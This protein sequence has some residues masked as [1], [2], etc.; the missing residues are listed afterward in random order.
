RKC[1]LPDRA[2]SRARGLPATSEERHRRAGSWLF[3]GEGNTLRWGLRPSARLQA[4]QKI[5]EGRH[6][7]RADLR[8]VSRHISAA[9]GAVAD[10]VDEL[11]RR[12][13]RADQCQI[14]PPLPADAFQCMAVTAILVLKDDSAL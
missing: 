5:N 7:V 10:L 11:V 6:L 4:R 14:G 3:C 13:A 1:R 9:G 12:Q 2:T 8:T